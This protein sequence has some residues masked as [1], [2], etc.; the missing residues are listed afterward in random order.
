MSIEPNTYMSLVRAI[1]QKLYPTKLKPLIIG[2]AQPGG[3]LELKEGHVDI[4]VG[5]YT[6]T[7]SKSM[8]TRGVIWC[9]AAD[10]N[11]ERIDSSVPIDTSESVS[12]RVAKPGLYTLN[13]KTQSTIGGF[14][15][16][17]EAQVGG[18]RA[19]PPSVFLA[20][21]SEQYPDLANTYKVVTGMPVFS[22]L[23]GTSAI[24]R[25]CCLAILSD[26]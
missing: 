13:A 7:F 26:T 15:G 23:S 19:N 5:W 10:K 17:L 8:K 9:E 22:R 18:S 4:H 2:K 16:L 20:V 3:I 12:H 1:L 11:C 21:D 25:A 6:A 24:A 14:G